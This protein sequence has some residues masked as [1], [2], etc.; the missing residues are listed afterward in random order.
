[1]NAVTGRTTRW[2]GRGLL[3]LGVALLGAWL[4][5]AADGIAFRASLERRLG[6]LLRS[7]RPRPLVAVAHASRDEAGASGL[8]GRIEIP[9]LGLSELVIEGTSG[10]TLRRGVG[11]VSATAFPGERGNVGLAGHRDSHFSRLKGVT[12]GDLIRIETP[13]GVFAYQV[14][15][16]RIVEPNR[17]DLLSQ[18]GG[19]RLTLVTCYPFHWVGPAPRRFVVVARPAQG[20]DPV[21]ARGRIAA[22]P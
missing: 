21:T 15:S 20:H 3:A 13:D 14:Q 10:R 7:G 2:L 8:I 6:A 19:P 16:I 17:G 4:W 9:R 11:H 5:A 18:T 22:L 12:R 1:M